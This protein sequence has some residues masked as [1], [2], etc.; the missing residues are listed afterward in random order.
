MC[1]KPQEKKKIAPLF[2]F[3][4]TLFGVFAFEVATCAGAAS[5]LVSLYKL[6]PTV[7]PSI[8]SSAGA[9]AF[10]TVEKAPRSLFFRH[11]QTATTNLQHAN[12][13]G[14]ILVF[15]WQG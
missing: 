6:V 11:S 5:R 9:N 8:G 14:R 2:I 10:P 13:K 15:G 12:L 1:D 3:N 7:T 4:G